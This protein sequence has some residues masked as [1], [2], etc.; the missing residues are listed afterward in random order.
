MAAQPSTSSSSSRRTGL[1]CSESVCSSAHC[2]SISEGTPAAAMP[3]ASARSTLSFCSAAS[4]VG[5]TESA[6]WLTSS[7]CSCAQLPSEG[8]SERS[9]LW[10]ASSFCS[11]SQAP[12]GGSACSLLRATASSRSRGRLSGGST[13]SRL[14]ST[15]STFSCG[16]RPTASG[17]ASSRLSESTSRVSCGIPLTASPSV[18]SLFCARSSVR[19]ASPTAATSAGKALSLAPRSATN[20]VARQRCPRCADVGGV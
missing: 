20:P 14:P 2:A 16:S 9:S 5:S 10:H 18:V 13:V 11:C 6:L 19:A 12:I 17:S 4:S 8:G 7:S 15:S 1:S 3:L